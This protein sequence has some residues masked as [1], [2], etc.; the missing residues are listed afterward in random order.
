[1]TPAAQRL[2]MP[3]RRLGSTGLEVSVIGFGCMSFGGRERWFGGV[4]NREAERLVKTALDAGVNL[5]DTADVY[6]VGQSEEILGRALGERRREALIATKVFCRMGRGPNQEGL[7][8]QHILEAADASL[9]RLKTG[10]IDLYQAHEFDE[11]TPLEE[12]LR[13]FEDLQRWGKVRYVGVS[14]FSAAQTAQALELTDRKGWTRMASNQVQYSLLE[15][16]AELEIAPQAV[17]QGIGVLAWSPLAGGFLS[18]KYKGGAA[19]AGSRLADPERRFPWFDSARASVILPVL[20][21]IAA[22]QRLTAAQAALAWVLAR[23]W[24]SS[25]IVGATSLAQLQ[26]NLAAASPALSREAVSFL[27]RAS[28]PRNQQTLQT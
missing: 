1:M 14:N 27:D 21:K 24:V 5:F 8:R 4:D 28:Q 13:A 23:P 9:R 7:S 18:G 10:H 2:D 11:R 20:D 12:S 6:N 22:A 17:A 16:Y 15:R 19:P 26:E 25:A 3:Y